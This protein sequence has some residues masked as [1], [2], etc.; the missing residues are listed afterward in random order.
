M[1]SVNQKNL[2]HEHGSDLTTPISSLDDDAI[3]V[4]YEYKEYRT[5]GANPQRPK[6]SITFES[7]SR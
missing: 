3:A 5:L 1:P 4:Q 2:V 6:S 7:L